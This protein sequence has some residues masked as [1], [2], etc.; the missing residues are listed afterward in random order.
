MNQTKIIRRALLISAVLL[1]VFASAAVPAAAENDNFIVMYVV[2]SDLETKYNYA[3]S[4]LIDLANNLDES[5]G[6]V[7]ICYG[8][9]TKTGWDN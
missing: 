4:N 9:A 8:G 5:A 3:S 2:G 7:I 1:L 6:D